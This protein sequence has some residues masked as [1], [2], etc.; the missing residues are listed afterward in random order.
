MAKTIL[1]I[2]G[3]KR[4]GSLNMM[5]VKAAAKGA[6]AAGASVTVLDLNEY[7]I[8]L[9]DGDLEAKGIPADVLKV[10]ELFKAHDGLLIASP[11]YNGGYTPLLK[12]L[13]DW[14]SRPVEG[15]GRLECFA[16]K[17]AALMGASP[18]GLGGIR[19][20]PSVAAIL[21]SIGVTILASPFALGQAHEVFEADGSVPDEGH[22]QR[23]EGLGAKLAKV[24]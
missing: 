7:D 21:N 4:K 17:T 1:A 24:L 6:E 5:L 15:E 23:I 20:L 11:E 2:S 22:R 8:P 16:G 19:A 10:K 3:S 18:G 13:I 9:Y 12:N 14:V